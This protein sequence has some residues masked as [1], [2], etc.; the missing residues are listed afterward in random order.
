M[1]TEK[2]FAAFNRIDGT[3]AVRNSDGQLIWERGNGEIVPLKKDDLAGLMRF[4]PNP[5]DAY[6][7][8]EKYFDE[9]GIIKVI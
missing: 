1:K 8:I 9:N 6:V 7:F 3:L 4:M 2:I 5:T